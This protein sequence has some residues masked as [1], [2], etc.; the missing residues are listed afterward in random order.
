MDFV[1]LNAIVRDALSNP[2]ADVRK[3][4][5]QEL[6]KILDFDVPNLAYFL[7]LYAK[8]IQPVDSKKIT[9]GDCS[10]AGQ[11]DVAGTDVAY[12]TA[13]A[14]KELMK[15]LPYVDYKQ[16]LKSKKTYSKHAKKTRLWLKKMQAGVGTSMIR[17]S[18]LAGVHGISEKKVKLGSKG[19]DLFIKYKGKNVSLAE[20]QILQA[21][22]DSKAG[23]YEE[24]ILHDIVSSETFEAVNNIWKSP[25]VL[26]PKKKYLIYIDSVKGHTRFKESIQ[27]YQPTIDD[28]GSLSL[29]RSNPGGH[30]YIAVD[31]FLAAYF[32]DQLPCAR[33]RAL[34][35]VLGNGEDLGSTPDPV[36]IGWIVKN[37]VPIVMLT[38]EKTEIDMK[39]GQIALV[40]RSGNGGKDTGVYVTIVEKAQAESAGQLKLFEQMG[41]R[42]G[43]KRSFFN[44]NVAVLN[45]EVLVPKI[46]KLIEEIGLDRFVEV[47]TPDLIENTKK[48]VDE[49]GVTRSYIQLEG[50]MGSSILNLDKFWREHYGEPIVHFINIDRKNRTQFFSPVK[51][52]FDFFMQFFSDKFVL[53]KKRVRLIDKR[54]GSL[55]LI[56]LKDD[57]YNDVQ[58]VLG[59]FKGASIVGLDSL[60][61]E[62]KVLL[63]GFKLKGDV[64]IINRTGKVADLNKYGKYKSGKLV[65]SKIEI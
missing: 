51:T 8:H 62:G 30:G 64:Q 31:A 26:N 57:F 61:I 48:Q 46:K 47:I 40:K 17:K 27:S 29:K 11:C 44:T 20:V 58:N 52:A 35:S 53:D 59:A 10:G 65:N 55:P 56:E 49:D 43:D 14:S 22:A 7:A 24:I 12:T 39:G 42:K 37:K 60:K 18:Y 5:R 3:K 33:S 28:A 41:L 6:A 50:A 32:T 4:S 54:P 25:C 21:V 34:V 1:N 45:Y 36:M 15:E 19:T 13:V 2:D 23:L 16:L 38:T 9:L 63:K